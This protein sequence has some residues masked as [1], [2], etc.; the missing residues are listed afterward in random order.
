M[1]YGQSSASP[2]LFPPFKHPNVTYTDDL[3]P[4]LRLKLHMLNLGHTYLA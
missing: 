4:Y 1:A 2:A 3:E